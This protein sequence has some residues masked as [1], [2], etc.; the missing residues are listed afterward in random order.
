MPDSSHEP[1]KKSKRNLMPIFAI[2]GV[3]AVILVIGIIV[4]TSGGGV[5][6]SNIE[7]NKETKTQVASNTSED[8]DAEN[9]DDEEESKDSNSEENSSQEEFSEDTYSDV[10]TE[11]NDEV[12]EYLSEYV[13][14]TELGDDDASGILELDGELYMLPCSVSEFMDDGWEVVLDSDSDQVAS[15]E[16]LSGY[17]VRGNEEIYVSFANNALYQTTVENCVV[18]II[19]AYSG[20][21]ES[22]QLP[23]G[24]TLDMSGDKAEE[25]INAANR[26]Y[27]FEEYTYIKNYSLYDYDSN[28]YTS[29][30]ITIDTEENV[31]YEISVYRT[32]LNY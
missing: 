19:I 10:V 2:C 18:D 15:Y 28:Y 4:A 24:V 26:E 1:P 13:T 21:V 11:T 3:V 31:V 22:L 9:E 32:E 5:E 20:D 30:D 17:L 23:S 14:P 27:E 7:E 25:K 6:D 12:P 8:A 29:V 16:T